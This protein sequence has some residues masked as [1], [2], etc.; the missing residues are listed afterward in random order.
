LQP[1]LD[2]GQLRRIARD[3]P[4]R[5]LLNLRG[6]RT[7]ALLLAVIATTGCM[8]DLKPSAE[9]GFIPT[10]APPRELAPRAPEAV[11]IY[12]SARPAGAYLEVGAFDAFADSTWTRAGFVFARMRAE[13]AAH[14]CEGLIVAPH[15]RT[16]QRMTL[17]GYQATCI[18]S[19]EQLGD[20]GDHLRAPV[21][22]AAGL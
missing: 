3:L 14:G 11:R 7:A 16:Y 20:G 17:A 19:P 6:M 8:A 4:A 15:D 18:V 13:A 2:D 12:T 10:N 5:F 1:V 21:V 9:V 22:G